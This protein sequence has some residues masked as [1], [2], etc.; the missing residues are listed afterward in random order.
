MLTPRQRAAVVLTELLGH[1][2]D[3][4][5]TELRI[6]PGTVRVLVSQA[7]ATLKRVEANDG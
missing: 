1:S 2:F 7:R 6:K 4:A 3:K 5:A